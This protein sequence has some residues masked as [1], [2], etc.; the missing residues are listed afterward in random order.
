MRNERRQEMAD[1]QPKE[2]RICVMCKTEEVFQVDDG[3]VFDK[4]FSCAMAYRDQIH[5]KF[6]ACL[7]PEQLALFEIYKKAVS[8]SN[9]AKTIAIYY[10]IM[11]M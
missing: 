4:C 5:E 10:G 2:K 1:E 6:V 11:D 8:A 3:H 9:S 7:S